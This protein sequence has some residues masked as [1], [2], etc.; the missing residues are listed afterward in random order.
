MEKRRRR[1]GAI[2]NRIDQDEWVDWV[3]WG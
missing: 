1:R 2:C 3:V